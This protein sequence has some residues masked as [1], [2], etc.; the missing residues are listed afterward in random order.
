[1]LKNLYIRNYAIIDEVSINFS[2]NLNVI[3]GETG[4]GKSILMG[5]LSLILGDRAETSIL[6][7]RE[8]K[9][10]VE[11]T[12]TTD[13]ENNIKSL[14]ESLDLLGDSDDSNEI[15]IRREIAA[16]GKS[17]AFVNDIPVNLEQL[18]QVSMMLVD[19]HRQFDTLALG[20]STFQREVIDALAGNARLLQA[21]QLDYKKWKVCEEEL[22]TLKAQKSSFEKEFDYHKFLFDELDEAAFVP[23]ELE[24]AESELKLLNNAETISGTLSSVTDAMSNGEQP[25]VQQL[26]SLKHQLDSCVSYHSKL[27]E[28]AARLQ[29]AQLELQDIAEELSDVSNE[30]VYDPARIEE[31]NERLSLGYK[32][33]K[34][35]GLKDTAGLLSL[36]GDLE[37]KLQSVLDIDDVISEKENELKALKD[38]ADEKAS[39]LSANRKK[40][41]A[42]FESKVNKLLNQVGMPNARL[43]VTMED[44]VADAFGKDDIEFLF[45]ANKSNRF[46]AIRK[47]ASGGELSRLML[48]IKSLVAESM[49]MPTLIFDEI[50]TGISGEAAKQV[51]LIMHSLAKQRQVITITHQPQIAGKANTHLFVYKEIRNDAVTTNIRHLNGEERILAIARMLSGEKPTAAALENAREMVMN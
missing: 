31:L 46:E 24:D 23:N 32:L 45:D 11:G 20:E 44:K 18:R 38:Q 8:K 51:G 50:D 27:E 12:F 37:N 4:V 22:K 1:M 30:V 26:K 10:F 5:A 39:S 35:H 28:L 6:L 14:L 36:K 34:K 3:T 15:V 2:S 48:S 47:V 25:L 19:L 42:P 29:S 49:D 13:A 43:K 33:L 40:H 9:C 41:L 21:Y 16:T 7:N 17:R